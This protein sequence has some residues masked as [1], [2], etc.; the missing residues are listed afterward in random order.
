MWSCSGKPTIGFYSL[1]SVP[2]RRGVPV[3]SAPGKHQ[4]DGI[5]GG[6]EGL[7]RRWRGR[8]AHVQRLCVWEQHRGGE[9]ATEE[10]MDELITHRRLLNDSLCLPSQICYT[11]SLAKDITEAKKVLS[12]RLL[13]LESELQSCGALI[14]FSRRLSVRPGE[15]EV[16]YVISAA[17]RLRH[18]TPFISP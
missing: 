8:G 13:H 5:C 1:F 12:S 10:L 9:G 14:W 4:A 3:R 6:G 16:S 7:E 2:A 15:R 11:I 18:H 17:R